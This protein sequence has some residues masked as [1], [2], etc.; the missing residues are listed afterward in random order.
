[1]TML[2]QAKEQET[3]QSEQLSNLQE[4]LSQKQ[5][6]LEEVEGVILMGL[7]QKITALEIEC[8]A[9]KAEKDQTQDEN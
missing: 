3:F 7:R 2:E 4:E 6:R 9:M 1:M 5:A 8:N